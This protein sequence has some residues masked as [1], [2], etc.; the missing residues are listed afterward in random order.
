M[1]MQ[2]ELTHGSNEMA[3]FLFSSKSSWTTNSK[4]REK[5]LEWQYLSCLLARECFF[6][7][8]NEIPVLK[9]Y[10]TCREYEIHIKSSIINVFDE[11]KV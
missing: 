1:Q 3:D 10:L 11:S 2:A 5:I 8:A 9:K 4:Q 7:S 6:I